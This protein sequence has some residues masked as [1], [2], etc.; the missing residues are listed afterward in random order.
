MTEKTTEDQAEHAGAAET[1]AEA[2]REAPGG[3]PVPEAATTNDGTDAGDEH[4]HAASGGS[5]PPPVESAADA[6]ADLLGPP[7]L[8]FTPE[9]LV[10]RATHNTQAAIYQLECQLIAG[11]EQYVDRRPMGHKSHAELAAEVRVLRACVA[12][13]GACVS[14]HDPNFPAYLLAALA[15]EV[16]VG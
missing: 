7:P 8:R 4:D 2:A 12:A 14:D 10:V 9:C 1:A 5:A 11:V 3:D 16:A 6:P 15:K 13:I